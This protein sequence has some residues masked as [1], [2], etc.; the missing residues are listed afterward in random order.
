M[1]ALVAA[2]HDFGATKKKDV[3]ARNKSAHDGRESV[4]Q[5]TS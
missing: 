5:S 1:A 4:A 3:D 2:I